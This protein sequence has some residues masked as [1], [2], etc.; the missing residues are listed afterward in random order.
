MKK[1]EYTFRIITVTKKDF[2]TRTY[3]WIKNSFDNR[4]SIP[5]LDIHFLEDFSM[6]H[7]FFPKIIKNTNI[8]FNGDVRTYYKGEIYI[9][10]QIIQLLNTEDEL[11]QNLAIEILRTI[12]NEKLEKKWNFIDVKYLR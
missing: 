11:N 8:L 3:F 9:E 7:V 6:E 1:Y 12:C 2:Y 4:V 5:L 10:N